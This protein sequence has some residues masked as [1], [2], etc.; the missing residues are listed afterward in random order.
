M[1]TRILSLTFLLAAF[2]VQN[3]SLYAQITEAEKLYEQGIYQLE[4]VGDFEEAINYFN[5]VVNEYPAD[6]E[7][8]AKAL[9]KKGFCYERLGS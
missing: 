1:K 6:K 7:I 8:A 2:F 5:K 9:L 4:G 3:T